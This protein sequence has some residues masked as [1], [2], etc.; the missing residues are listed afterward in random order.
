MFP[1]SLFFFPVVPV[2]VA[3]ILHGA[4][5]QTQWWWAFALQALLVAYAAVDAYVGSSR[6]ALPA[7]EAKRPWL[8]ALM[9]F[10]DPGLGQLYHG[11]FRK[12]A[13]FIVLFYI[14]SAVPFFWF[15]FTLALLSTGWWIIPIFVAAEG[16]T[17]I[18]AYLGAV[19]AN[20]LGGLPSEKPRAVDIV[21]RPLSVA[22]RQHLR[23][24]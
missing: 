22:P 19:L 8:A 14:P 1:F 15:L 13:Y 23:F 3:V 18:D 16:Y 17:T 20:R 7:W 6:P 24:R 11:E 10:A 21:D 4:L 5:L 12:G 9:S 2:W